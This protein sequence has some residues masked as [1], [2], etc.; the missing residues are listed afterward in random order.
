V[1]LD[2]RLGSLPSK[3]WDVSVLLIAELHQSGERQQ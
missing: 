3:A 1:D 2:E